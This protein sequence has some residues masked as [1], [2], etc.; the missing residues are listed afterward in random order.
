MDSL[1]HYA[2]LGSLV[3]AATGA[4]V[5]AIVTI[6]HGLRRRATADTARLR[7]AD[8]AAVLCFAVAAGLG[9]VGLMHRPH[10]VPVAAADDGAL[11]ERLQAVERRLAS[12]ELELQARIEASTAELRRWDERITRLEARLVAAEQRATETARRAEPPRPTPVSTERKSTPPPGPVSAVPV[13]PLSSTAVVAAPEAVVAPEIAASPP[14]P[15][16]APTVASPPPAPR[17][18]LHARAEPP[19]RPKPPAR[20]APPAEDP[21]LGTKLRRDWDEI[22]R[23]ARRSGDDLREG[24]DQLKRLFGD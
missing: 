13:P 7:L 16:R 10:A 3:A 17:E 15:A 2:L 9:V 12:A 11:V 14:A 19:A 21:S 8:T 4:L 5:L 22:K 18:P 24:W 6:T 1:P 23:T 20:V